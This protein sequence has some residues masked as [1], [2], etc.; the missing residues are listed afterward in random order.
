MNLKEDEVLE[1]TSDEISIQLP[2]HVQPGVHS[3]VVSAAIGYGRRSVGK[4]GNRTG[5][6][7]YPFVKV[8][9]DRL[10]YSG[11]P[12]TVKKT[13]RFYRLASTQ[14]HTTTENRPVLND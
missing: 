3:K 14:W 10:V 7:V 6:D 8:D 2:V 11:L 4:V 13:G 5:V 9:G 1:V 12:A